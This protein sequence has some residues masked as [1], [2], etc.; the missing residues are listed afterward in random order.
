VVLGRAAPR[1]GRAF[2]LVGLDQAGIAGNIGREDRCKPT[3]DALWI[4]RRHST[5]GS[6]EIVPEITSKRSARYMPTHVF[7]GMIIR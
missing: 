5:S 2:L 1:A 7:T 4:H 3:F 6:T